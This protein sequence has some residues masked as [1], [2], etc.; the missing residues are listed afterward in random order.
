MD[1]RVELGRRPALLGGPPR[2]GLARG[3]SAS[4]RPFLADLRRAPRRVP[5]A[6][7]AGSTRPGRPSTDAAGLAAALDRLA[8]RPRSPPPARARSSSSCRDRALSTLDRL[9]IPSVLAAGAVHTALTEAGLRGRT[10]LV[11][12]A[13]DVLDVHGAGDGARGRR[14]GGRPV[15]RGRAGGRDWPAPAAPRSSTPTPTVGNLLD[16][17]RGG[18]PQDARPDGDQHGRL[19]HRRL[20]VRVD[21]ARR[22]RPRPLLP[23]RAGVA[24]DGSG[25]PTS[26]SAQLRRRGG[27]PRDRRRPPS[28]KLQDPGFARFRADG[29]AHLLRAADRRRDPVAWRRATR[30]R[31]TP[32][33]SAIGRRW[34]GPRRSSATGSESAAPRASAAVDLAEVEPARDIARRFVVSRDVGRRALAGGPPGADDRHPARRRRREHRRGRRGS[35]LVRPGPRPASATTP[36]SSRSRRPASASPPQYLARGD[37]LEIKIAQGTK[38][39]E[40]GQLPAK[41]AT[42]YIA[43]APARPARR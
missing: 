32:P 13:A 28:N 14:H 24:R 19:V 27:R 20:P 35:R 15:A 29:E 17:V 22:R 4:S 5:R 37:Q 25:S 36:G 31:S 23:G 12:D 7:S 34:P 1:L 21:R 9:P 3:R 10:D 42:A 18:P 40:G 43:I 11:V 30:R 8:A 2:V 41:K 6:G 26:P 38:P 16:G 39:G 33:S